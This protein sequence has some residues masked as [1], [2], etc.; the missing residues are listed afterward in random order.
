MLAKLTVTD[1]GMKPKHSVKKTAATFSQ[2]TMSGKAVLATASEQGWLSLLM[3]WPCEGV[4]PWARAAPRSS[5]SSLAS[6]GQ[7]WGRSMGRAAWGFS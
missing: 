1:T 7:L 4:T 3:R 5:Q 2:L 6:L